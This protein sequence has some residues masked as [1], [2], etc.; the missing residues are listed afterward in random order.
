MNQERLSTEVQPALSSRSVVL[1][2]AGLLFAAQLITTPFAVLVTAVMGRHI[3]PADFGRLYLATTFCGFGFLLVEWGQG[4]MLPARIARERSRAGEFLGSALAWRVVAAITVTSLLVLAAKALGHDRE[5]TTVLLLAALGSII[6]TVTIACQD[7]AR[8]FERLDVAAYAQVGG[9]LFNGTAAIT[10][11]LLGGGLKGVLTVQACCC[12]VMLVLVWRAVRKATGI[13]KLS[14]SRPTVLALITGG[15]PL[16]MFALAGTLQPNIDALFLAKLVPPEVIGWHAAAQRLTGVL[17]FPANAIVSALYPTLCRLFAQ[18]NKEY[19]RSARSALLTTTILVV[20]LALGCFLYPDLGVAIYSRMSFGPAEDN[21]RVLSG[22]LFLLY[23]SMPLGC[24]LLAGGRQRAWSFV[25][26]G[27]VVFNLI[28]DP[29]LIP[30]FQRRYGNGGMGVC[31]AA[32]ASETFMVGLGIWLAPRGLFD[33]KLARQIGLALL[34]GGAMF[35]AARLLGSLTVFVAAPIA[36]VAYVVCLRL[37][38]GLDEEMVGMFR[39]II[40]RKAAKAR[41]R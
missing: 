28:L 26:V 30:W 22:Y 27:S 13:R 4:L 19:L 37:V 29:L 40:M 3:G 17:I 18:D 15:A 36:V 20:P 39:T 23:F 12:V 32:V 41:A 38:G 10:V 7:A 5:F 35:G 34:S 8:G 6:A 1:R 2:N 24:A 11:V 33:R 9:Q 21:L 14:V 25:Q 31:A 16:F